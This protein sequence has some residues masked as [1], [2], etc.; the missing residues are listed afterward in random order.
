MF[1]WKSFLPFR[2]NKNAKSMH[3]GAS[4]LKSFSY[5]KTQNI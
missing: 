2:H 4:L 1:F 3:G 5:Q